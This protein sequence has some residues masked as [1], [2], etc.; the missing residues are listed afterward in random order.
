MVCAN[1]GTYLDIT[2]PSVMLPLAAGNNLEDA[3][4]RTEEGIF[5][6]Q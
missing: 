6:S 5:V 1:N 4:N 2:I 3:L